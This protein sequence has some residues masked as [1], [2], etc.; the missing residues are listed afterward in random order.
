MT[1]QINSFE[2]YKIAYQKSIDN[3]EEFWSEIAETFTWQKKWT[4]V[5]QW[6]FEIPEVKWFLNAQF[7]ITTFICPDCVLQIFLQIFQHIICF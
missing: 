4:Q 2:A 1:P 5:L 6:N 3:P 7:N